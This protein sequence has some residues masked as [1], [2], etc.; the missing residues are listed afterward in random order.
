MNIFE[1]SINL[2]KGAAFTNIKTEESFLFLE[3]P[4]I[5]NEYIVPLTF[6]DKF[7]TQTADD[8]FN[9]EMEDN[10]NISYY[11]RQTLVDDY[12]AYFANLKLSRDYIDSYMVYNTKDFLEIDI[13]ETKLLEVTKE[14][15]DDYKETALE[16]FESWSNE[17]DYVDYFNKLAEEHNTE[18]KIF[19]DFLLKLDNQTVSIA[20]VIFDVQMNLAYIH[21]AGTLNEFRRNGYFNII[22]SFIINKAFDLGITRTYS[23]TEKD[24]ESYYAYKK[25]GFKEEDAYYSFS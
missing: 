13:K 5:F 11:L 17:G 18:D 9:Q 15:F 22:N 3:S 8:L 10:K 21:N 25:L 4:A 7:D 6:L 16:L 24:G 19:K 23:I 20:S 14:N 1:D 2:L 12:Q